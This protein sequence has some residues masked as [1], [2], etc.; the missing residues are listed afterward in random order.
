M[1]RN[2]D[3][4][5]QVFMQIGAA[6][7]APRDLNL[8]LSRWRIRRIVHRRDPDILPAVPNCGFHHNSLPAERMLAHAKPAGLSKTRTFFLA[9]LRGPIA[10]KAKSQTFS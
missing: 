10:K 5:T 7:T 1:L 9:K 4:T 6:Y 2:I 3:R 8:D